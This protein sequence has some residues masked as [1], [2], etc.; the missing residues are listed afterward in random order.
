[1]KDYSALIAKAEATNADTGAVMLADLAGHLKNAV[2]GEDPACDDLL[3][4]L[5]AD[6]DDVIE[7]LGLDVDA[8]ELTDEQQEAS[9]RD[10]AQAAYSMTEAFYDDGDFDREAYAE[11]LASAIEKRLAWLESL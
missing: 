10:D 9:G 8:D 2:K 4:E 11:K 7:A 1:M 6:Y 5:N 3:D